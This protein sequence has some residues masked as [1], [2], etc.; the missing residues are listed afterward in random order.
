MKTLLDYADMADNFNLDYLGGDPP[1]R[2]NEQTAWRCRICH[3]E[4]DRSYRQLRR[5]RIESKPGC[6]CGGKQAL[7]AHD[8]R[9]MAQRLGIYWVGPHLPPTS[10]NKTGWKSG[11]L[12]FRASYRDLSQTIP[13][14]LSQFFLDID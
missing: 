2:V 8:Y 5:R 6:R 3:R 7:K 14:R 1:P 11:D 13:S 9:E 12:I 4:F 10:R